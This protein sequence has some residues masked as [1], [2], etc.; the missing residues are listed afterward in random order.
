[1]TLYDWVVPLGALAFAIG[2][3]IWVRLKSKNH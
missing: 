3:L 2:G 1:M